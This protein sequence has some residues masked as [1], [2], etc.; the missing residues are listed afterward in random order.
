MINTFDMQDLRY[1]NL[2]SKITGVSTRYFFM[3][4]NTLIFCVPKSLVSKALGENA[5]NLRKMSE[6]LSKRIRVL[7]QPESI[8][9]AKLFVQLLINPITFNTFEI[10]NDKIVISAGRINKS[11]LIGREKHKLN[12]MKKIIYVFFK[13]DFEIV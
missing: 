5:S 4:N 10:K 12:E 8:K 3:Y 7:A 9:D 13:K 11:A 2:F 6:I 1:I